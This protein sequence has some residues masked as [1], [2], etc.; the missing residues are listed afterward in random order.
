MKVKKTKIEEKLSLFS[1]P[2]PKNKN[3][4]TIIVES[5]IA[6]IFKDFNE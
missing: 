6:A 2:E 1:S 5:I 4:Y 3:K